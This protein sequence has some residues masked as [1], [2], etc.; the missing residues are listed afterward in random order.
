VG[1]YTVAKR[2]QSFGKTS[3]TSSPD[4]RILTNQSKHDSIAAYDGTLHQIAPISSHTPRVMFQ[5][6]DSP[7]L[8]ARSPPANQLANA[9]PRLHCNLPPRPS[10]TPTPNSSPQLLQKYRPPAVVFT[11]DNRAE[12]RLLT[13]D[14]QSFIATP[15]KP[16]TPN[17]VHSISVIMWQIMPDFYK[18]YSET[19]GQVEIGPLRFELMDVHWQSEKVFIVPE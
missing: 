12:S 19:I 18:W 14:V 11:I 10:I 3:V 13:D 7:L 9:S 1:H 4:R 16:A 6:P 2:H 8:L 15:S 5:I 17:G